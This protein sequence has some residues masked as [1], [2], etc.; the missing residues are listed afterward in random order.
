MWW[1]RRCAVR[2]ASWLIAALLIPLSAWSG[3][4]GSGAPAVSVIPRVES[5]PKLED[6]LEMKPAHRLAGHLAKV[7]GFIQ[8]QPKDGEPASQ[9]TEVYLGYDD[10]R[11]Y[12]I[13]VAFDSEPRKVRARLTRRENLND[14][15]DW[16][17][18]VL[19]TFRDQRRGYLFDC[20]PLGVQWDAL[21]SES[22]GGDASFDTVWD[23][24][25]QVTDQ[26]YV[27]WMAIPF[28]SLRFSSELTQTWGILFT[29]WIPR[30]PEYSSWPRYSSRLEGRLNQAGTLRG[31]QSISP[32]RNFQLI[33]YG[34]F[35]SFQ[36]LDTRDPNRP[37][38]VR[39][40]FDPNVGL[41]AKLVLKDSLVL[42]ATVNPDF[43]QV[44]SDEPQVTVNQRFEVYFPE[45]R[46]FFIEN[47]SFFETPIN[48]L[49]TRRIADPQLGLRLTGKLGRYSI[50][51]LLAD[52]ES[53]GKIVPEGDPLSGKRA[54]FGVVRISRDIF[55]QSTIGLIYT[56]RE[57]QNSFNR[58]FGLDGRLKV[59][60]NWVAEFQGVASSTRD[61]DGTGLAGPAYEF[62]LRREGRQFLYE[63]EYSDRSPGFRTQAGFV[64]RTDIRQVGQMVKYAFRPEAKYLISWGPSVETEAI[65]DH[66]GTRLDFLQDFTLSWEL[67]G[68]TGV[69][70]VYS[71]GRE[72]LR[73]QDFPGLPANRDFARSQRG[74]YFGTRYS[75]RVAVNG[76]YYW[77]QRINVVPPAGQEPVL[78]NLTA[79]TL[80][81]ALRPLTRL[82]IENTYIAER[83]R[84]R[85]AEASIFN[86]HIL[87]SKW[88]WQFNRELSLRAIF[89][90]EAVLANQ[91][92]TALE[93]TKN[94]NADFLITYLLNPW[95][96]LYVGYNSN[97]QNLFLCEGPGA[98]RAGCPDLPPDTA[99]LI[100]P[101]GQFSN[102]A[103]QFF[104]KFSYL[105]R[106]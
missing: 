26:G 89:Q 14:E 25:G 12:V 77:G 73:P 84:D 41:D 95:T 13:F 85:T 56:D 39:D 80:V 9:R 5:P 7:E 68:Q 1:R 92:L 75:R 70:I 11:L 101:P 22:G 53:P 67:I 91:H 55:R 63:F 45:K 21:W 44:E 59:G 37:T 52:D 2:T 23:S 6:F 98:G 99:Q 83:L 15:D 50:G 105:F 48:L 16:V 49:F 57:F 38:F 106:F 102:D 27:V 3:S 54:L 76:Q 100:R 46:P 20:N 31:L 104:V 32:G 90:Y 29:R 58:V 62:G 81:L 82:S 10:K 18:V 96:A 28:K 72:R 66:S 33:P 88:N 74:V 69:G 97:L 34:M 4:A 64:T 36:A 43:S 51:G 17:E 86:N 60:R 93:T 94:F 47:A 8:R 65:F 61:V 78:A 87:R 79:G 40:R 42:D 19:D 35:R 24:R 103:K 30:I 71:V